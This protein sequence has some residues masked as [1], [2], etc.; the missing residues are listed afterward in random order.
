LKQTEN[1]P[2]LAYRHEEACARVAARFS[3]R[4][5]RHYASSKLRS[6]P[7]FSA[8]AEILRETDLPLLDVGCGVGLLPFYLRERGYVA[9]IIGLE[10]D[11]RKTSRA[12]HALMTS[13]HEIDFV[14]HNVCR[15]LPAFSGNIALLD[16]LHYLAP[17][18]QQSLLERL[19][20]LVAP[21][22]L[23]IIRDC[24]RDAS[25]RFWM[26]YAGELFAQII[27]WNIGGTLHFPTRDSINAAFV[28]EEF[29][30]EEKPM[31]TGGP[32]NNRIFIFR[33]V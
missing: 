24:P 6:D 33:R 17:A 2:A 27:S 22:G 9:P 16:V 18:D 3:Q 10:I 20:T 29:S 7:V 12:R 25:A 15:E 32:F 13:D 28:R 11:G 31:Y 1:R 19:A 8:V 21:G 14:E 5:L 23:L 30:R 26:T 4:W